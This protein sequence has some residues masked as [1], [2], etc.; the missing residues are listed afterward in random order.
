[1]IASGFVNR[2][3]QIVLFIGL[4]VIILLCLWPPYENY[5]Y[6]VGVIR[7]HE[8]IFDAGINHLNK[9]E[10]ATYIGLVIF[11]GSGLLWFL[12]DQQKRAS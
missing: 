11:V 4:L 12:R 8:L 6:L 5:N 9:T 2:K 7:S 10:L 3:Q 1:M